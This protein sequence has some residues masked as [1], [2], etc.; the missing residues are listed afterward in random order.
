VRP[1]DWPLYVTEGTGCFRV[2]LHQLPASLPL[3]AFE[4]RQE[5]WSQSQPLIERASRSGADG[6]LLRAGCL[7][8]AELALLALRRHTAPWQGRILTGL[9]LLHKQAVREEQQCL[10]TGNPALE[11]LPGSRDAAPW[12][13]NADFITARGSFTLLHHNASVTPA[14][15]GRGRRTDHRAVAILTQLADHFIACR[16]RGDTAP[17][18]LLH[19]VRIAS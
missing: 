2:E 11:Q 3:K 8:L 1:I 5:T 19:D 12:L 9:K 18:V 6:D 10:S 15:P 14:R 7:V 16:L 4:A 17:Y 13:G